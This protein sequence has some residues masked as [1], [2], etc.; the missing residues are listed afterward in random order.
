MQSPWGLNPTLRDSD[1]SPIYRGAIMRNDLNELSYPVLAEIR[2]QKNK[3]IVDVNSLQR[4]NSAQDFIITNCGDMI[5]TLVIDRKII[6]LS[7][8]RH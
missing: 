7:A 5:K 1:K 6:N 3:L 4:A 2:I 8:T